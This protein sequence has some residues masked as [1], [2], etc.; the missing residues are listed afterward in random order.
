MAVKAI[1]DTVAFNDLVSTL[2]VFGAYPHLSEFD[3]FIP[4][5]TQC[6][7]AIKNAIKEEQKVRVERQVADAVNQMNEPGLMVSV[8]HDLPL[9]SDVPV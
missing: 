2:L 9:D 7:V 4:T 1:N 8:V 6:I 5:I 3:V